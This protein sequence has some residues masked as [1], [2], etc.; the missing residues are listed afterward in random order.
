[1][2]NSIWSETPI[3][4]VQNLSVEVLDYASSLSKRAKDA[5]RAL[6]DQCGEDIVSLGYALMSP[7]FSWDKY[8]SGLG[9]KSLEELRGFSMRVLKL[10][11]D[12][13]DL[14][15]LE[16]LSYHERI[17]QIA[18]YGLTRADVDKLLQLEQSLGYFPIAAFVSDWISSRQERDLYIYSHGFSI[19][20][21]GQELSL[22][23]M[24]LSLNVT[25][26]RCRQI[27][28]QL[29]E[30][31]LSMLQGLNIEETCPYDYLSR[32]L[33]SFVNDAE[34]TSFNLNFIRLILGNSYSSLS[35]VGNIEDSIL[36]KLRGGTDDS[37]I[38][39]VPLPIAD[40]CDVNAF[41]ADLE[42]LN[43]EKST[44]TRW[45]KLPDWNIDSGNLAARLAEL[46][47]GW[48]VSG[49][50]LVIPPNADKN[51]PGIIEDIIRDAG[52]PLSIDEIVA[53]YSKRYPDRQTD[54]AKIRGNIHVNPKIVPIGRTG[55]YSLKE[56][57]SGSARGGTIRSFVRECLD[58][59]ETHIVPSKD[60]CEY[61]RRFRPSSTDENIITNLKLETE[62]SFRIIWKDGISYLTYS[63]GPVPEGYNQIVRSVVE[64]RGFEESIALLEDFVTRNGRMPKVCDNTEETR[65]ARFLAIQRSLFRRGLVSENREKELYRIENLLDG[66][67]FELP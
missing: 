67:L 41:L 32:D 4:H 27:R 13:R 5:F 50:S 66:G 8:H 16:E 31:L 60:V 54:P 14:P 47:Y 23:E 64:K 65:L 63:T 44:E 40:S 11:R 9:G 10:L 17:A 58:N 18:G 36:F 3:E 1:M 21:D 6:F 61:V 29:F 39:A 53:E 24:A 12:H 22:Q 2:P 28:K 55:V 46:R 33:D 34:G 35:A 49:D 59:S 19:W 48:T 15:G 20:K 62:R 37:F 57:N 43:G 25:F 52:R 26:E 51:R 38:A 7:D 45:L 42:S 56:W 30:E